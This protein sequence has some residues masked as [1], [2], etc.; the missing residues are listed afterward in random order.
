MK[1]ILT[2]FDGDLRL[3]FLERKV[4]YPYLLFSRGKG[5]QS[6]YF[7]IIIS[8][9]G[10]LLHRAEHWNRKTHYRED[11]SSCK[12]GGRSCSSSKIAR[13]RAQRLGISGKKLICQH[14][15]QQKSWP[16]QLLRGGSVLSKCYKPR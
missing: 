15:I 8:Q 14:C 1:A 2:L 5:M 3:L 16:V 10:C 4:Q 12:H 6:K 7:W 11:H 13:K 9:A